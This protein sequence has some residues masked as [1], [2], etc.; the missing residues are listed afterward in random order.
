MTFLASVLPHCRPTSHDVPLESQK[1]AVAREWQT[2]MVTTQIRRI[3]TILATERGTTRRHANGCWHMPTHRHT[4]D[5]QMHLHNKTMET[6]KIHRSPDCSLTHLDCPPSPHL[7]PC[8]VV[9]HHKGDY[10]GAKI[11]RDQLINVIFKA[12]IEMSGERMGL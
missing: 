10:T 1:L 8:C 9:E 4:L 3:K 7:P 11:L 6:C 12:R 5:Q 2:M